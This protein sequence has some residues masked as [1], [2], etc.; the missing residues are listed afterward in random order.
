[1]RISSLF[2][3]LA[4]FLDLAAGEYVY[5]N[6]H[7]SHPIWITQVTGDGGGESAEIVPAYANLTMGQSSASGVAI[8]ITP[9]ET[10]VNTAGKGV[11][12]L[13]YTKQPTGWMYYDLGVHLYY[14]FPGA[15]VKLVGPGGDNDWSD[16]RAH[17]Q[18]TKGY[19]G[20]G[21]LLLDIGY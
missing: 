5:I 2:P 4:I 14:P 11:L 13:G 19:H 20:Q 21:D 12:T 17:P 8:K 7:L 3:I 9:G 1:M 10:D 16:G 15:S 6:N 18:D